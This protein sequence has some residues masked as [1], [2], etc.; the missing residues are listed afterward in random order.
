MKMSTVRKHMHIHTYVY[1]L[2]YKYKCIGDD[3]SC[4]DIYEAYTKKTKHGKKG[5]A[6]GIYINIYMYICIYMYTYIYVYI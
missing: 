1:I 4:E 2:I 5:S 3:G 6:I